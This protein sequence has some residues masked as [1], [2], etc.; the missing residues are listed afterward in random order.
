MPADTCKRTDQDFIGSVL[1]TIQHQPTAGADM[2]SPSCGRNPHAA[3]A[4]SDTSSPPLAGFGA[5]IHLQVQA[6]VPDKL[7]NLDS[8]LDSGFLYGA[9]VQLVLV[10]QHRLAVP[11]FLIFV[12]IL[13]L[14][15]NSGKPY[16][17][18]GS[19]RGIQAI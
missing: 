5:G 4:L 2:R 17:P 11:V 19:D 12:D 3:A 14:R 10:D 18:R 13:F 16:I 9:Y 8:L 15:P 7:H 6:L 1:G